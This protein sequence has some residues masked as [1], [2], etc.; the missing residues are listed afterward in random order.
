[1]SFLRVKGGVDSSENHVGATF[2][3]QFPDFISPQGI[4]GVDADA[5]YISWLDSL[6]LNLVER[7]IDKDG[8]SE[9]RW[10]GTGKNVLPSWCDYCCSEGHSAGIDQVNV[11]EARSW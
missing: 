5:N 4:G 7:L 6:F 2:P 3:R 10:S 1:M 8:I 9:A 11:Q